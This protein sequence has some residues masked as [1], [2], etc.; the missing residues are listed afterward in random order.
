MARTPTI[1]Q[2]EYDELL[3]RAVDLGYPRAKIR[4]VPQAWPETGR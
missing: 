3:V 1:P 4:R 2:A